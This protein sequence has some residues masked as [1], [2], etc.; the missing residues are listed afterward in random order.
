[1]ENIQL[2]SMENGE[3][4]SILNF[5]Q[6]I[7]LMPAYEKNNIALLF[8]ASEN[9]MPYFSTML[10]SIIDYS[11]TEFNYDIIVFHRNITEESQKIIHKQCEEYE[12]I[13]VRFYDIMP[14]MEPYMN[15][16]IIGHFTIE[17]YFRLLAPYILKK[18]DKIVYL[19]SDIIVQA[20]VA[21]LYNIELDEKYL[22]AACKDADSAGLYNGFFPDKKEYVD[23]ILR[24]KN[25]YN[26]FQSGVLVLNC[27]AFRKTYA[28]EYIM[29]FAQTQQWHLPDQDILNCLAED[30]VFFI[31]MAWNVMY[32]WNKIRI[33]KIIALATPELRSAYMLARKNP[34]II[35][36]AGPDKPWEKKGV[37]FGKVWWKY[38]KQTPYIQIL[39]ADLKRLEKERKPRR[40]FKGW[41]KKIAMPFVNLFFPKGSKIREKLKKKFGVK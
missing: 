26:Y 36:Y 39:K 20:D 35:H 8:A 2:D 37:D 15:L 27:A 30:R 21:K 16:H 6:D 29:Q 38:A 1:M 4:N 14:V 10:Q 40:T 5:G 31:D 25:P 22:L 9:Y 23:T 24:L 13:T 12:N 33:Q 3:K 11:S 32:D 19:D 34:Y 18:Y 41:L 17:M 28:S 7:E